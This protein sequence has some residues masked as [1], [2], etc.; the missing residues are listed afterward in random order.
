MSTKRAK[1]LILFLGLAAILLVLGACGSTE[2]VDVGPTPTTAAIQQPAPAA[3]A[4][5]G[6][7]AAKAAT[8]IPGTTATPRPTA[9]PAGEP[10][11]GGIFIMS[12]RGD[13]PGWDPM[14]VGTI[15][16]NAVAGSM[17]GD[18]NL[19]KPC[20]EDTF[21]ICG[22]LASSW[23]PNADLSIWTLIIRDGVLWHDGT[24]FT[25]EDA[26]FWFD[27]VLN[28]A[29]DTRRPSNLAGDL[30]MIESVEVVGGNKLQINL[31]TATPVFLEILGDPRDAVAHPRHLMQP[32]IDKGNATV[33]PDEVGWVATGPFKMERYTKGSVIRVRRFDKYWEK[34]DKGR[35]LPYLDGIDFAIVGDVSTMV[36]AFRAGRIDA[37]TRGTGFDILPH[38]KRAITRDLGDK[39]WFA[40]LG[41]PTRTLH[42]NVQR[43][44]W[45]DVRVRQAVSYWMDREGAVE[46]VQ[47]GNA[48]VN[49]IFAPDSPWQHPDLFTWPGYNPDTRERDRA[50]AKELLAEAGFP[51]G[52]EF[53]FMCRD[54]WT[55]TC[56]YQTAQ[57]T[58]LGLDVTIDV[59]D[60]ATRSQRVCNRDFDFNL[61]GPSGFLPEAWGAVLVS[62]NQ[63]GEGSTHGDPKVDEL[64]TQLTAAPTAEARNSATH[65][66]EEYVLRDNA[67]VIPIKTN[68]QVLAFRDYVK[69]VK[70]P[71]SDLG[72]NTDF[73]T[74]WLEK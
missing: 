14:L 4:A 68:L 42:P 58:A 59:V 23:E 3:T 69:G 32:E 73:A 5:P 44:P 6:A 22:G 40:N 41:G 20:R 53:S 74:V 63:C 12:N 11:Y 16:L 54:R 70:V 67:Y 50:R 31:N 47:G 17:Y 26:R 30:A 39:A 18:G 43:E 51:N 15:T 27:L 72:N 33:S 25:I 1:R 35:Q 21:L 7:K 55:P 34:D 45:D 28:G 62:S 13:P 60:T 38:Q 52:F 71:R 37:T 9:E 61:F 46:A 57:M 2:E 8:A 36:A 48:V 19:V 49:G 65:A 24:P 66:I 56:E 10:K 29:G 64:F